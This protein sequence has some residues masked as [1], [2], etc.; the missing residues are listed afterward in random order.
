MSKF[1]IHVNLSVVTDAESIQEATDQANK[2]VLGSLEYGDVGTNQIK[3]IGINVE[4]VKENE[5]RS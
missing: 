5:A 4:P 2:F 1:N 3:Y